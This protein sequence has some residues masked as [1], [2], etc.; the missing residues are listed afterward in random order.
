AMH[1]L[2]AKLIFHSGKLSLGL[3]IVQS[4]L[5]SLWS[6]KIYYIP[7]GGS[8]PLSTLG[9]TNA[10]LE[11]QEQLEGR[12]LP[13]RI[14]LPMGTA[15]TAAGLLVGSCLGLAQNQVQIIAVGISH[16]PLSNGKSVLS[17][18]RKSYNFIRKNLSPED[19]A[20]LPVCDLKKNF[21][22]IKEYSS[23]GYG[24]AHPAVHESIDLLHAQERLVLDA[25]YSGK[26]F[27]AMKETIEHE[28]KG[29]QE[30]PTTLF[31]LTYRSHPL[32]QIIKD[33]PWK[34]PAKPHLDLP[35]AFHFLFD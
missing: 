13:T 12:P 10:F 3:A 11:L 32:E 30:I 34:N 5:R 9:Y 15:G 28:V 1:A 8:N 26:A 4:F 22:Y 16:S 14:F 21:T 27:L 2:G 7:P 29:G 17:L 25:T 23:P 20:R 24:A 35:L 33:Y 18:A 19:R 6:K 31:W